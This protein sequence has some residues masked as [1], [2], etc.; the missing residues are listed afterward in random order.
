MQRNI[1]LLILVLAISLATASYFGSWYDKFSPQQESTFWGL[2]KGDNIS[3]VGFFVA[4]VFFIS[5]IYGLSG[6]RKNKNW[7]VA[8]L[9]LP[10][11]LWMGADLRHIYLPI[12]LGLIAFGLSKLLRLII[13][14]FKHSSPPMVVK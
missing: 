9:I 6:F 13:S 10:A 4:Y 1:L 2:D 8:L 11:L 12:A 5:L 7:I 3:F 14:K